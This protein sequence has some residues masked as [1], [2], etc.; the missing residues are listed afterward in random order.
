MT[1]TEL[2]DAVRRAYLTVDTRTLGLFR[3]LF[4]LLLLVDLVRHALVIDLFFVDSGV[5]TREAALAHKSFIPSFFLLFSST[6]AVVA[7]HR[8]DDA[9]EDRRQSLRNRM[10]ERFRRST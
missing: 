5:I 7:D 2:G 3:V 4:G 9:A 1:R 8:P 10:D 6:P